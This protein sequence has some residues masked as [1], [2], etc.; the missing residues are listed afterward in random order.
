MRVKPSTH[1]SYRSSLHLHVLPKLG[2]QRLTDITP[3]MLDALY[4]GL[5]SHGRI[6]SEAGLSAKTVSNIHS[7]VHKALADAVDA[8][9]IRRNPATGAKPPRPKTQGNCE[10]RSWTP[11]QLK[12]FLSSVE[13]HRLATAWLLAAMTGMRRG[14]VLGTRWQDIDVKERTISV[15]RALI[16]VGYDV[17]VSTP[18]GGRPRLVDLAPSTVARLEA[19]RQQQLSEKRRWGR[20]YND[21]DLVFCLEDGSPVHPHAFSSAFQKAV[22]DSGRP[23]IRLHDLRHTHATIALR[24]GIPIKV[25]AERLGHADPAFTMKQYAHVIP[26]MQAEAAQIFAEIVHRAP[27]TSDS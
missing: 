9:L 1:E 16:A 18:K 23:R 14:E 24:A 12:G 2:Q 11:S 17:Q 21:Q 5:F 20:E 22:R 7:A 3:S 6:L 4:A 10:I 15:R 13:G 8:Q 27:N 19:H 26:G 25:I